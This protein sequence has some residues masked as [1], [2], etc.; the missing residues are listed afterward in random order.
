MK[1]ERDEYIRQMSRVLSLVRQAEEGAVLVFGTSDK[2]LLVQLNK[3]GMA[4]VPKE[5]C[6]VY[7]EYYSLKTQKKIIVGATLLVT[8]M[9]DPVSDKMYPIIS[10]ADKRAYELLDD[11]DAKYIIL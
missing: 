2:S 5:V 4:S 10:K 8:D 7:Q 11:Y 1:K 9:K 6:D 3:K